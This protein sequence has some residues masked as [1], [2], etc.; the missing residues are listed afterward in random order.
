MS[1]RTEDIVTEQSLLFAVFKHGDPA[2]KTVMKYCEQND[3]VIRPNRFFYEKINEIYKSQGKI[4]SFSGFYKFLLSI[5][6]ITKEDQV[7]WKEALEQIGKQ[8]IALNDV[9]MMAI[10]LREYSVKRSLVMAY[11]DSLKEMTSGERIDVILTDLNKAVYAVQRRISLRS[12]DNVIGFKK[13]IDKRTEY[14]KTINSNPIA[15]G[16]VETSFDNFDKAGIPP[17]SPGSLGIFQAKVNTGKSMFL[18]RNALHNYRRGLKVI[19]IT[20]EMAAM[21]YVMRMDSNVS[22]IKHTNFV[23]GDVVNDPLYSQKWMDSV[24]KFGPPDHDLIIY[25][26]PDRCTTDKVDMLVQTNPFKPDLVVV[27]YVGNMDADIKNTPNLSPQAQ[28]K[29][30]ADLK[31]LAG[32]HSC[33]MLTAQQVKRGF[34]DTDIEDGD[35]LWEA[36]AWASE[37]INIADLVI[38]FYHSD[39]DKLKGTVA[40]IDGG[41]GTDDQ[42]ENKNPFITAKIVKIRNGI[43][44]RTYLYKR[45]DK[46][47]AKEFCFWKDGKKIL[48]NGDVVDIE[49]EILKK[50]NRPLYDR[51][52]PETAPEEE[53]D[54][55]PDDSDEDKPDDGPD[56][57]TGEEE[58][59]IEAAS[60]I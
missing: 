43:Y 17:L 36:G 39:I 51:L 58:F 20:I 9:D 29:L 1:L 44:L 2:L 56:F 54:S 14:M 22:E 3:F 46:M 37:A 25:R 26:V 57:G 42:N 6:E 18:M 35:E 16:L 30:F 23:M 13:D 4:P 24:Q 5:P 53:T 40:K 27:D 38:I 49:K 60:I 33:V 47:V 12:E 50:Y 21:D 59:S 32:K 19:I 10:R 52:H 55:P 45:F 31:M 34:S 11:N 8:S 48:E 41:L 7:V 28:G 15:N